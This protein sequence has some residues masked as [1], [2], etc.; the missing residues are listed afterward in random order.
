L[1][2]TLESGY[3]ANSCGNCATNAGNVYG[4]QP[5]GLYDRIVWGTLALDAFGHLAKLEIVISFL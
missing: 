5:L 4:M 2:L 3:L 1:R